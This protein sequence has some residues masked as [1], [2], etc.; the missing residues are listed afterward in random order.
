L[1]ELDEIFEAKNPRQAST[2]VK[3]LQQ[4]TIIGS[5]GK[6]EQEIKGAETA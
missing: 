5:S 2:A 3:K 1:E 6:V 4:R